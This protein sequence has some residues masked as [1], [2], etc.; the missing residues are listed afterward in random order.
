MSRSSRHKYKKKPSKDINE[1]CLVIYEIIEK[2][3]PRLYSDTVD[4]ICKIINKHK[5]K[6]EKKELSRQKGRDKR[7]LDKSPIIRKG[8][9]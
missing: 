6:A 1:N 8:K 5:E 7:A 2:N 4:Q 3:K 9:I